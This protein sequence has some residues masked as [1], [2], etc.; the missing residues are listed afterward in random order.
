MTV[1]WT[2]GWIGTGNHPPRLSIVVLPLQDMDDDPTDDYL[3]DAITDDLTTE[4]ARLP[5]AA[6]VAR[7]SAYT[8]NVNAGVKMHR[9]A[10]EK[11]HR[12]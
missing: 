10:G 1:V 6:V 3:A 8:Y 7:D 5:G 9:R 2:S 12:R 11:M 4:L